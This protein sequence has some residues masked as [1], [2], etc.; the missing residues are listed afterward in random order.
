MVSREAATAL[1]SVI[2]NNGSDGN[3]DPSSP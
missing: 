2:N 3:I 1:Q